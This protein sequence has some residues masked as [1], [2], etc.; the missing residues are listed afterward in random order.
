M[1]KTKKKTY[2]VLG[3]KVMLNTYIIDADSKEEALEIAME[4]EHPLSSELVEEAYQDAEE[5]L[6]V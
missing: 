2:E 3:Y 1:P 4:M 6:Y 5:I